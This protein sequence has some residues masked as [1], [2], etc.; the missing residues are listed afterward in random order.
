MFGGVNVVI[1]MEVVYCIV[2]GNVFVVLVLLFVVLVL[3]FILVYVVVF[4]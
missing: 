4:V 1:W 2:M 3:M